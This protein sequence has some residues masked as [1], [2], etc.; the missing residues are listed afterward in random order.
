MRQKP[1]LIVVD[2]EREI[3]DNY[4]DLFSD[5]FHVVSYQDPTAFLKSID[6]PNFITPEVLITDLKMPQMDGIEMIRQAQKKNH[7]FPF[8]L[9]SGYLS[10][11]S[12]I[13]AVDAG[14][15]RLIEKPAEY[16][17]LLTAIEQLLIEHDIIK[18]RKEIR[19]L[20]S[21]L[22]EVYTGL[23]LL[24]D[25]YIPIEIRDRMIVDAPGGKV[26]KKIGF[27]DLLGHLEQRLEK[28]LES[29]KILNEMRV[30]KMKA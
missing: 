23:R 21:Q 15:F 3:I 29:E 7:F 20:T 1:T 10:K 4:V 2:D 27:D 8:I 9:L 30:N 28:L 24:L 5:Q 12:S 6:D 13:N 17:Q 16:N 22:R 11:E 14:A 18:I 19:D 25:Q 26:E